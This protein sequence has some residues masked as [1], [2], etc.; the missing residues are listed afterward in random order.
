MSSTLDPDFADRLGAVGLDPADPGDSAV[1]WRCLHERFGMGMNLGIINDPLSNL[2]P[3]VRGP[4]D[5]FPHERRI[6]AQFG[7]T[8]SS[9]KIIKDVD[10]SNKQQH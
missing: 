3:P 4:C 6:G 8:T 1:A 9:D 5:S 2:R 10:A 7:A